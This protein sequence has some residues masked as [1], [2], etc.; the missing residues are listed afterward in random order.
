MIYYATF[1]E[2]GDYTGF[3]T[4]EIHGD[5]IP[6]PNVELTEEQWQEATTGRYK[7]VDGIHTHNPFTQEQLD[8]KELLIVKSKRNNLLKE[9]D[10]TQLPNNPLTVEKQE[11]W[12]VYRQKLR[13]IP[14]TIPYVFPTPP[15]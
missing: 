14:K 13:D 15:L 1:N 4:K 11:E 6:T 5:S 2:T 12:D 3:Y 7:L 10:W 9:S 8:A